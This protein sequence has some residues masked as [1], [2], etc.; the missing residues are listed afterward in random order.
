MSNANWFTTDYDYLGYAEAVFEDPHVEFHGPASV[1]PDENGCPIV[2]ITV[3][4]SSP[5]VQTQFDLAE[6][7]FGSQAVPGGGRV[8]AFGGGS[9]NRVRATVRGELGVFQSGPDWNYGFSWPPGAAL[10]LRINP[11]K[12]EFVVAASAPGSF[13]VLP[14]SAFISE[15]PAQSSLIRS[16][17]LH[18]DME[19]D[20][21]LGRC[22][23]FEVCGQQAFI[24]Q[25]PG[26]VEA[27]GGI[28]VWGGQTILTAVAVLPLVDPRMTDPW[29][30]FL[31]TFLRLLELAAGSEVGVPW[32]ELRDGNGS[33]ARRLHIAVGHFHHLTDGYGAIRKA[34]HWA[35]GEYLTA[36]LSSPQA[37]QPFFSIALRHCIRAGLPGLTLDDQLDHLVRALECLCAWYGFSKQDL[38]DGFGY[39]LKEKI[40]T[41]LNDAGAEITEL[42]NTAPNSGCRTQVSRIAERVQSAAQKDQH[43]GLAVASLVRHFGLLDS[44]VLEPHYAK[45]PGPGGRDWIKSLSY[46]RGAVFHEG[47]VDIDS[48][49]TAVGEVFGFTLHL[50]DL[51][52]RVLL[53]IIGYGGTYQPRLIRGTACESADWFKP[54]VRVDSL[55]KVPTLGIKQQF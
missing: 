33:L 53:K 30:W 45:H 17:P 55:L 37:R 34:F 15:F 48:P 47:F 51:V 35:G 27:G 2:E 10:T 3:E 32:I 11:I 44:D 31:T 18:L 49:G 36:A 8:I 1:R 6:V 29:G 9:Q 50:H 5:A 13:L 20:S 43:F 26:A 54:G 14:L 16:H 19:S 39:E 38:T 25:L 40:E 7:Q 24:Q 41:T 22:I 42:A 52:V 28:K 23:P 21:H 4:R 46:Y 12:S